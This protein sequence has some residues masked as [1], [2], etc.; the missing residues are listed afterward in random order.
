MN[1]IFYKN[2][3]SVTNQFENDQ[4]PISVELKSEEVK[5]IISHVPHWLV[6]WGITLFF[7]ILVVFLLMGWMIRFPQLV[8]VPLRLTT[9]NAPKSV[10]AR[11]EGKLVRL[12]VKENDWVNRDDI[13]GYVESSCDHG[14]VLSL[15]KDLDSILV[16]IDNSGIDML[17]KRERKNYNQLGDLQQSYQVFDQAYVELLAALSNGFYRDKKNILQKELD[18]LKQLEKILQEQTQLYQQD[19][20]LAF[21]EYQAQ[22]NLAAQGVIAKMEL[23]KE[24]SKLLSKK[25]PVKQAQAMVIQNRTDQNSKTKEIIELNK[26]IAFHQKNF[27]QS[28]Y[29]LQSAIKAWKLKYVLVAPMEGNV[30]FS[31]LKE[32]KQNLTINEELFYISASNENYFGEIHIPQYNFGKVKKGQKVLIKLNGYPFEEFG[33]LEGRLEDISQIPGKDKNFLAKVALPNGLQT[34]Y[35][36]QIPYKSGMTATAQIITEEVRM[37]ER[38]FYQ[39]KKVANN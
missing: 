36:K 20:D 25:I 29:S 12:F 1:N 6:R 11:T 21:Q 16:L 9:L 38:L 27:V 26:L 39:F 28:I 35:G 31:T 18:E 14:Q 24:E 10:N 19:F 32:E 23:T 17:E 33:V 4:L 37:L 13:L 3:Q 34:N 8:E 5:E 22:K 15:A 30:F 7:F 2:L